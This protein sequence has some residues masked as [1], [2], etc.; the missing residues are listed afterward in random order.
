MEE[1]ENQN[2]Q[3]KKK[4]VICLSETRQG[5]FLKGSLARRVWLGEVALIVDSFCQEGVDGKLFYLVDGSFC[6]GVIR[7]DK[8][9][10]ITLD[11]FVSLEPRH[12]ISR[13]ELGRQWAGK[14]VLF[15]YEFSLE[16]RFEKPKMISSISK[17][18]FI[19]SDVVVLP[20]ISSELEPF[21]AIT[22]MEPSVK[23]GKIED[24]TKFMFGGV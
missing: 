19:V 4:E 2:Q 13:Q 10:Q 14:Q 21:S 18:E 11:D 7:I 23:F 9:N 24:A 20:D 17:P 6:Y 3:S 8:V 16:H 5:I 1:T 12:R 15:S 22:L